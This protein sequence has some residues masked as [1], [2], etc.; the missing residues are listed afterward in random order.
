VPID[1]EPNSLVV[2]P[3]LEIGHGRGVSTGEPQ[4]GDFC[5]LEGR[6]LA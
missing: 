4:E 3:D 5:L 2:V 6:E 1:F